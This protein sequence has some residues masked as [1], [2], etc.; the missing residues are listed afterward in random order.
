MLGQRITLGDVHGPEVQA[1][2]AVTDVDEARIEALRLIGQV[3]ET[4]VNPLI[5]DPRA[6]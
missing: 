6:S 5:P 1:L 2:H 3:D 4:K